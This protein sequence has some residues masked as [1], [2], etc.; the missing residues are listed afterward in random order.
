MKFEDLEADPLGSLEKLYATLDL[1]GFEQTRAC[2]VSYLE[3]LRNY[4]KNVYQLDATSR[5]KVATHWRRT[6]EKYGYPI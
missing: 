6:F 3:G 4:E 5:E 2:V 1:E